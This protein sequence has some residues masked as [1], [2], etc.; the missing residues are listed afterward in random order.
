MKTTIMQFKKAL[1]IGSEILGVFVQK[2]AP[3]K[4]KHYRDTACT[5]LARAFLNRKT[6]FFG[7]K[8]HPQL[9]PGADYFFGMAGIKTEE[10][11]KV[12]VKKE[13]VFKNKNIC[14]KFLAAIP[15]PPFFLK[16]G[17]IVIKPLQTRD[18]PAIVVLLINPGQASRI[19]GLL[20][21]DQYNPLEIL[22]NQ[23]SCISLFAP[24]ANGKT[25]LNFIDYYDRDYQGKF[26][27]KSVWPEEKMLI[28]LKFRDFER[29]LG[30]LGK[31]SQG[32]FRPKLSPVK[33]DRIE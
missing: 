24:L 6:T 20:N 8:N 33:V 9:C 25:H 19:L 22:P 7:L 10:I 12:Y 15:Q 28:S 30:N 5:A 14:K 11:A 13:R 18:K 26:Q 27:S 29:M 4:T 16:K 31:S 3:A 21:F 1:K 23:P 32:K 2:T 17:V